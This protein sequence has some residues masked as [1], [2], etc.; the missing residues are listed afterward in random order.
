MK[1]QEIKYFRKDGIN[2]KP[3]GFYVSNGFIYAQI[4][5]NKASFY[6]SALTESF[7]SEKVV[8]EQN[9]FTEYKGGMIV[10]SSANVNTVVD[11]LNDKPD[12]VKE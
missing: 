1:I 7:L 12:I 6:Q 4:A 8:K 5:N 2:T 10:F 11:P 3:N 9:D